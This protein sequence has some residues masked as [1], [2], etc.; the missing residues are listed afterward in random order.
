MRSATTVSSAA[1]PLAAFALA[2]SVLA[3]LTSCSSPKPTDAPKPSPS[4]APASAP[5]TAPAAALPAGMIKLWLAPAEPL[6]IVGPINFVGTKGLG[7]YLITT[8]AGHILLGG[9]M[10]P[11]TSLIEDSIRKLGYRPKDIKVLLSNHAHFDHVGTL[12]DFKK[13]TGA[14][15]AAMDRDV[16]LLASGGERDYLFAANPEYHFPPVTV[17]RVLHDG[18]T[19]ELGEVKLVAH[20]TGGHTPGCTTFVTT[21]EEGGKSYVVVFP[22]GTTVNAGTRFLAR[23]SYPGILEDYRR[24]FST[25]E[26]LRPDVFLAYHEGHFDFQRK[27]LRAATLGVEAF[28]DPEGYRRFVAEKKAELEARV[29]EESPAAPAK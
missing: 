27:R 24:T 28:V 23:P 26:S 6:H 9:G 10:P 12:A 3:T 19:V 2:I 21:V 1:A 5:A 14:K 18:D 25:L 7:V 8:R 4:S 13:R 11:S 16:E 22:D 20:R 17:D 29:A 15:V